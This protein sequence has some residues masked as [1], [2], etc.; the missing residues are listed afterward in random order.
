MTHLSHCPYGRFSVVRDLVPEGERPDCFWCGSAP[1]RFRYGIEAD[2]GCRTA[3][4][5]GAF[6]SV[7]CFRSYHDVKV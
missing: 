2:A 4:W 5:H 1:G 7:S 6:C 3:F